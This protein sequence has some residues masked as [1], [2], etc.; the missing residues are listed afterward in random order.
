MLVEY[1]SARWTRR[2]PPLSA[3]KFRA[4]PPRRSYEAAPY[5]ENENPVPNQWRG[6]L[7]VA[8]AKQYATRKVRRRGDQ[9]TTQN[10]WLI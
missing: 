7:P 2:K 1:L 9:K 8:R 10:Q 4:A 3:W 5:P 6:W